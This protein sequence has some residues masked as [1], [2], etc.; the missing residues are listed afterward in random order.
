MPGRIRGCGRRSR[1]GGFGQVGE[2]RP[3]RADAAGTAAAHGLVSATKRPCHRCARPP[4]TTW[5][6]AAHS[7][8]SWTSRAA[9]HPAC[10]QPGRG[11]RRAPHSRACAAV[12]HRAGRVALLALAEAECRTRIRKPLTC[13]RC[14][15]GAS[16]GRPAAA[17]LPAGP[18]VCFSDADTARLMLA[19]DA[20]PS[21]L[22]AATYSALPGSIQRSEVPAMAKTPPRVSQPHTGNCS[23]P[24]VITTGASDVAVDVPDWNRP[25]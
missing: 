8:S 11:R 23:T 19:A 21:A 14:P 18:D 15:A 13:H 12:G 17:R 20:R 2:G 7:G 16:A 10:R 3:R 24:L 9:R 25:W 6:R 22:H 1:R 5:R 4:A